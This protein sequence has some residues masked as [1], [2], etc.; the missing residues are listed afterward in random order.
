MTK[1]RLIQIADQQTE[2]LAELRNHR[3]SETILPD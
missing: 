3:A 2:L 1:P